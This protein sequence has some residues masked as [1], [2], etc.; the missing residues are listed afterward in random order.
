MNG[1]SD[2]CCC[3]NACTC[4]MLY[5]RLIRLAGRQVGPRKRLMHAATAVD[6]FLEVSFMHSFSHIL[7]HERN[8]FHLESLPP[9]TTGTAC[10]FWFW[11]R[12]LFPAS[13]ENRLHNVML[14]DSLIHS[15]ITLLFLHLCSYIP[16]QSLLS[17]SVE[18][19]KCQQEGTMNGTVC[20]WSKFA[21]TEVSTF[22]ALLKKNAW[23]P[24]T[25]IWKRTCK[26]RGNKK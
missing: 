4:Y 25:L 22:T 5:P 6:C 1:D 20:S 2:D 15:F 12:R 10:S 8:L 16:F 18:G 14:I 24:E 26:S 7:W 9:A 3:L 13:K 23:H 21:K 11:T 19:Q 17:K